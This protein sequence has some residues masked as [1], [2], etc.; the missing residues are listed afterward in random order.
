[1]AWSCDLVEAAIPHPSGAGKVGESTPEESTPEYFLAEGEHWARN[2]INGAIEPAAKLDG[3]RIR[4][5]LR[6]LVP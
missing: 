1:M 3:V 6:H 4:H 5:A 2:A